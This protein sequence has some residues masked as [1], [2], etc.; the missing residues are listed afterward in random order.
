M[1]Q[2]N[3]HKVGLVFGG[4]MVVFHACWALM[5]L[6]GVAQPFMDWIFDLHMV[7]PV[8]QVMPFSWG[9]AIILLIITGVI[10]YVMGYVL[11]WLWNWAHSAS[12]TQV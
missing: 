4:M 1:N 5:I 6:L 7:T 12:H 2:V 9:S 10:G 8:Y 3:S 11:G